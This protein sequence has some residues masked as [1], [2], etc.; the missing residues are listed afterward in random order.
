MKLFPRSHPVGP[1][2]IRGHSVCSC[3]MSLT[4]DFTSPDP[5]KRLSHH[6]ADAVDSFADR[7]DFHSRSGCSMQGL[8][9]NSMR[10]IGVM[11]GLCRG[12]ENLGHVTG[13]EELMSSHGR[14][15]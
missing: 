2:E 11:S 15:L 4:D 9:G 10:N 7:L 6:I 14:H 8:C 3:F 5:A 13:L 1:Y 12:V